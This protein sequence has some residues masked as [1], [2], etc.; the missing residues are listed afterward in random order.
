MPSGTNG[1]TEIA[2]ILSFK[3][4]QISMYLLSSPPYEM[5]TIWRWYVYP[6][7]CTEYMW[8]LVQEVPIFLSYNGKGNKPHSHHLLELGQLHII[9]HCSMSVRTRMASIHRLVAYMITRQR[10]S[11]HNDMCPLQI[12][13]YLWLNRLQMMIEALWAATPTTKTFGLPIETKQKHVISV[14]LYFFRTQCT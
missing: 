1:V 9:K 4:Q 5:L 11:S 12:F 10:L 6:L 7:H 13:V 3:E 2:S 14:C 8:Y